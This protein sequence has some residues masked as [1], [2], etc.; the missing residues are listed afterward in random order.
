MTDQPSNPGRAD[1][2]G[3]AAGEMLPAA[4]DGT[5]VTGAT[6]GKCDTGAAPGLEQPAIEPTMA[7][8]ATATARRDVTDG[9]PGAG[10]SASGCWA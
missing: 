6:V 5:G 9:G 2:A 4:L 3:L 10:P 1:D 7:M 8:A